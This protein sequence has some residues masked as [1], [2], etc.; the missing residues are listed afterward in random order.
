MKQIREFCTKIAWIE[1]GKLKYFGIKKEV[2]PKYERFLKN[3]KNHSLLG[4]NLMMELLR[5]PLFK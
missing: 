2:L 1:G 4:Q 5:D 3:F